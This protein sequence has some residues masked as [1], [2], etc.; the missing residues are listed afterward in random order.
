[1]A[2][3]LLGGRAMLSQAVFENGTEFLRGSCVCD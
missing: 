3:K 1:M 2:R